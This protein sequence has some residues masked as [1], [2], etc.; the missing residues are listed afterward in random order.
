MVLTEFVFNLC[1]TAY[2]II[3][4]IFWI[5]WELLYAPIRL[6]LVFASF[7][8]LICTSIYDFFEELW[9]FMSSILQFASASEAVVNSYEVPMWRSL[10]NDLFSQ[11][12]RR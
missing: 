8:A 12:A 3:Y 5:L 1:Q 9:R 2:S 11:V 7:V 10:W 4:P 6:V